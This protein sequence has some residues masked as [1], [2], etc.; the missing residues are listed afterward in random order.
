MNS[1]SEDFNQLS[2]YTLSH[3]DQVYFIHQ[4]VVDAFIAQTANTD[5]KPIGIIFSLVGLYLLN[6][7]RYTG[8]QIQQVHMQMSKN[9]KTWPP[10]RIPQ[11][12]GLL[13][14]S[15]V[16]AAT[17]GPDRD[18]TIKKW[19]AAVWEAYKESHKAIEAIIQNELPQ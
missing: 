8:R 19:C 18:S 15:D 6:E 5:T 14:I 4:H 16:L 13:S 10:I 3:P 2:F 12:K 9:K 1:H 11:N 17:P 7:K